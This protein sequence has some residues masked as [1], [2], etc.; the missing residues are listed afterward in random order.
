MT[1]E[2]DLEYRKARLAGVRRK[3]YLA[4]VIQNLFILFPW[5]ICGSEFCRNKET[6]REKALER[7]R[8]FVFVS[9]YWFALMI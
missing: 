7:A 6:I 9:F 1:D 4:F 5:L 2:N 3:Y 8:K